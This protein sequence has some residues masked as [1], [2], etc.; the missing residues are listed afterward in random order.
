MKIKGWSQGNINPDIYH[1]DN[2]SVLHITKNNVGH[3]MV[4]L[5][6]AP[7]PSNTGTLFYPKMRGIFGNSKAT[8]EQAK[9]FAVKWMKERPNA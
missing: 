6:P 8:K 3:N 7:I 9:D 1:S 5:V 2:G 4:L